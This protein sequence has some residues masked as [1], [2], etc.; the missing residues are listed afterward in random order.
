MLKRPLLS[1]AAMI[2]LYEFL[3]FYQKTETKRSQPRR[4]EI[5]VCN[6]IGVGTTIVTRHDSAES[7]GS[8]SGPGACSA[9]P[10]WQPKAGTVIIAA[11][12]LPS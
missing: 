2:L 12:L 3:V 6:V 4:L 11:R 8:R 1:I 9:A 10:S 5:K 7:V